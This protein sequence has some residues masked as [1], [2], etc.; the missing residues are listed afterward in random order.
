L[1]RLTNEI[2]SLEKIRDTNKI[3][4]GNL[5]FNTV[6]DLFDLINDK[7]DLNKQLNINEM[8]LKIKTTI[9]SITYIIEYLN[10]S[11]KDYIILSNN[12]DL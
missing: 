10:S 1:L 12:Y 4:D 8:Y 6:K 2:L 3:K 11:L 7:L 9:N 5:I